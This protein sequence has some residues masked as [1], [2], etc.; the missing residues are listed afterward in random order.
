MASFK[1]SR[2]GKII[3]RKKQP[4]TSVV[5]NDPFPSSS[6]YEFSFVH[7][8]CVQN[9]LINSWINIG[10]SCLHIIEFSSE[11]TTI[12]NEDKIALP[13]RI[14]GNRILGKPLCIGCRNNFY[15]FQCATATNKYIQF[16]SVDAET[17]T[18]KVFEDSTK[19][20]PRTVVT[21]APIECHISQ[22]REITL[23]RL[24]QEVLRPNSYSNILIA[25]NI[26]NSETDTCTVLKSVLLDRQLTC[27]KFYP[28]K[29]QMLFCVHIDNMGLKCV[30]QKYDMTSQ[31]LMD[32]DNHC[33]NV[34]NSNRNG[35]VGSPDNQVLS[36]NQTTLNFNK[37]ADLILFTCFP[38]EKTFLAMYA[39]DTSTL[40]I[41]F[42]VQVNVNF[43]YDQKVLLSTEV[44]LCNSK[45]NVYKSQKS[46]HSMKKIASID[47][48]V[49]TNL[50]SIVRTRILQDFTG[51]RLKYVMDSLPGQLQSYLTY[52]TDNPI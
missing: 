22:D 10:A 39:F 49:I 12:L 26:S 11:G 6:V 37:T 46:E 30:L 41:S 36:L 3:P 2:K 44:S 4:S 34:L 25:L 32:S 20:F 31:N 29:P 48:P 19:Y 18:V 24:P 5:K 28:T 23:L 40:K 13:G 52:N 42:S 43:K 27:V 15:V 51:D 21:I 33:I 1:G 17:N 38:S 16:F 47:F 35:C 45:L 7:P 8:F 9:R 14:T 50:K